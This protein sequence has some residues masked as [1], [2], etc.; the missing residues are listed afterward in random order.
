MISYDTYQNK[1]KRL[2]AVK[3]FIVRFRALFIALFAAIIA[4]ILTFIFI[5]GMI[6]QDVILPDRIVYGDNYEIQAPKALFSDAKYQFKHVKE[7]SKAKSSVKRAVSDGNVDD[8]EWTDEVPK[9]AG[10]YLVRVVTKKTFGVSYGTPKKFKIEKFETK[11]EINTDSIVYGGT[12]NK[13]EYTFQ[14]VNGDELEVKG[15]K[16]DYEDIELNFTNICA[17]S[18]SFVIKNAKTGEDVTDCYDITSIPTKEGVNILPKDITLQLK[19]PDPITYIG[20]GIDY[21]AVLS[22]KTISQ[23]NGDV[24]NFQT[25]II[26][27]KTG[28]VVEKPITVGTYTVELIYDNIEIYNGK[29]NVR[30]HYNIPNDTVRTKLTVAKR[31]VTITESAEK[32]YD[33]KPLVNDNYIADGLVNGHNLTSVCDIA[34]INAGTYKGVYNYSVLDKNGNDISENYD[35]KCVGELKITPRPIKITTASDTKVYDGTPLVNSDFKQVGL[36]GG[37]TVSVL[38]IY[39]GAI[40]AKTYYNEC[41]Y[42]IFEGEEDVTANYKFE[43]VYGKLE[44]SKRPLTITTPMIQKTYDGTPLYGTAESSQADNL[45]DCDIL[46]TAVKV[47]EITNFGKIKNETEFTIARISFNRTPPS[48]PDSTDNYDITY[49]YGELEIL[50]RDITITAPTLEKVYD[51]EALYGNAVNPTIDGELAYGETFIP[52]NVTTK[53]DVGTCAN[54]TEYRICKGDYGDFVSPTYDPIEPIPPLED[55]TANY[56]IT[57]VPGELTV[58]KRNVT[59]YTPT[60]EKY[61]DGKKLFGDSADPVADNLVSGEILRSYGETISIID[62]GKIPNTTEYK[63]YRKGTFTVENAG[64]IGKTELPIEETSDNYNIIYD[65]GTLTVNQRPIM[66]GT[67]YAEKEYDGTPLTHTEDWEILSIDN[68][69]W[70]DLLKN[71]TLAVDDSSASPASITDVGQMLNTVIYKVVCD[72]KDVTA[73]YKLSYTYENYLVITHRIITIITADGELTYNG[74]AFSKPEAKAVYGIVFDPDLDSLADEEESET[75]EVKPFV[76][77]HKLVLTYERFVTNAG[78]Y[79]NDC[80][81]DIVNEA[82][83]SVINN[84]Q[85]RWKRGTLTVNPRP[86]IITTESDVKFYDGDPLSC[87]KATPEA[88]NEAGERGIAYGHSLKL[89]DGGTITEITDVLWNGDETSSAENVVDFDIVDK[90]GNVVTENY[91][92]T[93]DNGTLTI[94]QRPITIITATA[95]KEFD[96]NAFTK[97][98]GYSIPKF[99]SL[100][101]V[102]DHELYV[103]E[104][105]KVAS[106]TFV[107]QGLVS[108][109]IDYSIKGADGD[110]TANYQIEYEYGK[111]SRTVR[112]VEVTSKSNSWVYDGEAH[113]ETGYDDV[114]IKNVKF[115]Q[116]GSVA[117]YDI[118]E[119]AKGLVLEHT[120]VAKKYPTITNYGEDVVNEVEYIFADDKIGQNYCLV[121]LAG[122]KLTIDKRP[123]TITTATGSGVYNDDPFTLIEAAAEKFDKENKSGMVDGH[124][125]VHDATRT[126]ASVTYVTQGEVENELYYLIYLKGLPQTEENDVTENYAITYDYGNISVTPRPLTIITGSKDK[127]YDGTPLTCADYT[128]DPT[129]ETKDAGLIFNDKHKHKIELDKDIEIPSITYIQKVDGKEVNSILNVR[130]YRISTLDGTVEL[131]A[132]YDLK[133]EYGTLTITKRKLTITTPTLSWPY[134]GIKHYGWELQDTENGKPKFDNLVEGEKG[135]G[136]IANTWIIDY[137]AGGV[138]ND[139]Y[140]S[141]YSGDTF[142]TTACYDITYVYGR[143]YIEKINLEITTSSPTKVYDG[144]ALKGDVEVDGK[145]TFVGIIAGETYK[146]YN[147][148]ARIECGETKN[149]TEYS[150]HAVRDG[151]EV[152][153]TVNYNIS[154][155]EGTIT[156]TQRTVRIKT[157]DAT[158]EYNGQIFASTAWGYADSTEYELVEG[159]TLYAVEFSK[160][161]DVKYENGEIVGVENVVTYKVGEISGSILDRDRINSNYKLEYEYG[162]LTVTPRNISVTTESRSW[163]YD[164]DPH[165]TNGYVKESIIHL[166]KDGNA[167]GAFALVD[168]HEL[169]AKITPLITV[170]DYVVDEPNVV[171]YMVMFGGDDVSGNYSITYV[172]GKLNITKRPLTITTATRDS[173]YNGKPFSWTTDFEVEEFNFANGSGI[174]NKL[175]HE[176][177]LKPGADVASVTYVHEGKVD[178]VL[179]FIITDEGGNVLSQYGNNLTDNYDIICNPGKLHI[180]AHAISVTNPTY[181]KVYD[182]TYLEGADVTIFDGKLL[183]NSETVEANVIAKIIDVGE[184][185]NN[186]TYKILNADGTDITSSYAITYEGNPTLSITPRAIHITTVSVEKMYDGITLTGDT[187]TDENKPVFNGI[188]EGETY[189]AIASTVAKITNC[190]EISNTTQY[191]IF[192]T[193]DGKEVETTGNYDIQIPDSYTYG[194]LKITQRKIIIST[195]SAEQEFDGK[196]LTKTDGYG[197]TGDRLADGQELYVKEGAFVASMTYV[198]DGTVDENGNGSVPN[199][200]EYSVRIVGGEDVSENYEIVRY[201]NN[202]LGEEYGTLTIKPRKISFTTPND[203][204]VYNGSEQWDSNPDNRY[205]DLIHIGGGDA[206]VSGHRLNAISSTTLTNVGSVDN[207]IEYNIIDSNGEDFTV[208]YDMNISW[209]TLTI[210]PLNISIGLNTVEGFTYGD[211]TVSYPL[212]DGKMFSFVNNTNTV[213]NETLVIGIKYQLNG[214]DIENPVNAGTYQITIDL[215]NTYIDGGNA[216]LDNYNLIVRESSF[217]IARRAITISL[218]EAGSKTY[219]GYTY[220]FPTDI[221]NGYE[222]VKGNIVDGDTLLIAVKYML[223]NIEAEPLNAGTYTIAFDLAT[224]SVNDEV[225]LALNYAIT[226]DNNDGSVQYVINKRPLDFGL[227]SLTHAYVGSY[228]YSFPDGD[229]MDFDEEQIAETDYL[230]EVFAATKLNGEFILAIDVG[231]YDYVVRSFTVKRSDNGTDVSANYELISDNTAT[232]TIVKREIAVSVLFSDTMTERSSREFINDVIDLKTEFPDYGPYTSS[233]TAATEKAPWG[234]YSGDLDKINAVFSFK[235]KTDGS[236]AELIELGKYTVSV[237][238]EDVEGQDVLTRN[239]EIVGYSTG[240]FEITLRQ[241]EVTAKMTA[242]QLVYNAEKIDGQWLSYDTKH[243]FTN[244]VGFLETADADD[245]D[246][247]YSLYK[248]GDDSEDLIGKI[249]QAGDYYLKVRLDYTGEKGKEKYTIVNEY[250]SETFTVN[251]RTIYAVTPDVLPADGTEFVYNKTAVSAPESYVTYYYDNG[252]L[253]EDGFLNGDGENVTP[254]YDYCNN[255]DGNIYLSAVHAGDYTIKINRFEGMNGDVIIEDNYEVA[256]FP[257]DATDTP[258]YGTLSIKRET[259]IVVPTEHKVKY[260]GSVSEISLPSKNFK[261]VYGTLY[262]GDKLT[263]KPSGSVNI[264]KTYMLMVRF[265]SV[266]VESDD[267]VIDDYEIIYNYSTLKKTLPELTS[268]FTSD[269]FIAELSFIKMEVHV[270]QFAPPDK[271]KVVQLGTNVKIELDDPVI[272]PENI[273]QDVGDG[274]ADGHYIKITSARAIAFSDLA[275]VKDW[276]YSC[277][278]YDKQGNDVSAGYNIIIDNKDESVYGDTYIKVI[279]KDIT[280][281]VDCAPSEY[282]EGITEYKVLDSFVFGEKLTLSVRDGMYVAEIINYE[283]KNNNHYYNVIFKYPGM[284]N[285]EKEAEYA[286]RI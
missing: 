21:K 56:N 12:L 242:S 198:T 234:I 264:H 178:N 81:Y 201:W 111:I 48:P 66:I 51:G 3:N 253:T 24:A 127:I 121:T 248:V 112:Y 154:Y 131:T 49:V 129:T 165:C 87:P 39:D 208:N 78:M 28:E 278:V 159:H 265:T 23:L 65:Y 33:G 276:I 77:D 219:D 263:F 262:E 128:L 230:D 41:S 181:E 79:A 153:T 216:S 240:E 1:I 63:I 169:K 177:K 43:Y 50:Q 161:T 175:K 206:L 32:E 215:D 27:D 267:G 217:T 110:V 179:E 73:N 286:S 54:T 100:S 83:E 202:E 256:E 187:E 282:V 199:R 148:A 285:N 280:V 139:L 184:I 36:I 137:V 44:I 35:I 244:T 101:L 60:I 228:N 186:T 86:I 147:I 190:G 45:A 106:V 266:T 209:G 193:R 134:D 105:A 204:F 226:C 196:T 7:E 82:G 141:I 176:A 37:H 251:K 75:D 138:K 11:F 271:Y 167:D 55:V 80:T 135:F 238:L 183:V 164:G 259:I 283:G 2:A 133:V 275:P 182:G 88:Y 5:K 97:T 123:L 59:I 168:K 229:A 126:I 72:G 103:K 74:E 117:N 40:D 170:V 19:T 62:A 30:S 57:L 53:L 239:Y 274:L 68:V 92:V 145:P 25:K 243:Y 13:G 180:T 162:T 34:L 114:H 223:G 22:E 174:V 31:P 113:S 136:Y 20:E 160:I 140:Y 279:P 232:F 214:V 90:L 10:D 122:G 69:R 173:V 29:T 116:D 252:V 142:A 284:E 143:L 189:K 255:K 245:Y 205:T 172:Y 67:A 247:V 61:Y 16:F 4:L 155:N 207:E 118:D 227:K 119:G 6:T 246:A 84:Y 9:R 71:H 15:L 213:E 124:E 115:N 14:L 8:D 94:V 211:R 130:S 109:E 108:N 132:N 125:I 241:I 151:K 47:A 89:R 277:K 146:A 17:N 95:T 188:V 58:T 250:Q 222:V 194:T 258:Q 144:T 91:D 96:G 197:V 152:E 64:G 98:D 52:F 158:H 270:K 218:L 99:T 70:F 38:S 26:Y 171:E 192:A 102:K 166:D 235:R 254:V 76:L 260:D 42:S 157:L 225:A 195:A 156:V 203:T 46:G 104:G 231:V 191:A 18:D 261:V 120:L 268:E 236:D 200:I 269:K 149:T 272:A 221:N 93:Y 237:I 150:I 224:C 249:L 212:V 210:T 273:L 257:V 281:T 220:E 233:S 107:T 85:V 163:V 185:P